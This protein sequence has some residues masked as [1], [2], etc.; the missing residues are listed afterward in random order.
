MAGEQGLE[1]QISRPERDVL[2]LHHSPI[3]NQRAVLYH[4]LLA[5][6]S[7]LLAGGTPRVIFHIHQN[8]Q[9]FRHCLQAKEIGNPW[10]WL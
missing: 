4:A 3:L 2:P 1:P 8:Q 6:S 5:Q 10:Q 7:Q 9:N